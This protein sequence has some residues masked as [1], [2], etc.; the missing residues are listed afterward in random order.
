[1]IEPVRL[2]A[3][4]STTTWKDFANSWATMLDE[5]WSVLRDPAHAGV[6]RTGRNVMV[7]HDDLPTV[8][9]GVEVVGAVT[10]TGR[11]APYTLPSG[12][13]ATQ[14]HTGPLD[15]LAQTHHHVAQWCTDQGHRTSGLRWET[16]G[17]PH[18]DGSITVDVS[19]AIA[20]SAPDH[21]HRGTDG[22]QKGP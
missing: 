2:V 11:V 9:V 5:V 1:M 22:M 10:P 20:P 3:V 19:W 4:R 21:P 8:T 14:T 18:E 6:V 12:L 15:D 16:Y 13:V 17:H 7:F